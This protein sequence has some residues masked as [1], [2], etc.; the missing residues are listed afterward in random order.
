MKLYHK[1]ILKITIHLNIIYLLF[2]LSIQVFITYIIQINILQYNILLILRIL[3][4]LFLILKFRVLIIYL[5][6]FIMI[7]LNFPK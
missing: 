6:L 2:L 1:V 3:I 5:L 4:L 7:D